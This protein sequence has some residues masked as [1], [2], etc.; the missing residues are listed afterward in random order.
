MCPF[1]GEASCPAQD[2]V[3]RQ[4]NNDLKIWFVYLVFILLQIAVTFVIG[5]ASQIHD[6]ILLTAGIIAFMVVIRSSYVYLRH[7]PW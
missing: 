7:H 3:K 1:S 4:M 6:W 2:E 5:M